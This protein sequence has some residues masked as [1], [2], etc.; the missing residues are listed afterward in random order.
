MART[1][2]RSESVSTDHFEGVTPLW[3]KPGGAP[4]PE[5][6]HDASQSLASWAASLPGCEPDDWS[7]NNKT[8]FFVIRHYWILA[9]ERWLGHDWDR[10]NAAN[11]ALHKAKNAAG[12]LLKAA[13][14]FHTA[15]DRSAIPDAWDGLGLEL[16]A[17]LNF[18]EMVDLKDDRRNLAVQQ[19]FRAFEVRLKGLADR[20]YRFGPL[21]YRKLPRK[22]PPETALSIVL[23]DIVTECRSDGAGCRRGRNPRRVPKISER[24]PWKAIAEFVKANR[25][26]AAEQCDPEAIQFKVDR[27]L[28]SVHEIVLFP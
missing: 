15:L 3:V 5:R 20:T 2:N 19:A 4:I 18:G 12:P 1:R 25:D 24:T 23:A 8:G 6:Y 22:I 17:A 10:D 13:R 28:A 14:Q 9:C 11:N 16:A 26:D 21:R 27:H 7:N